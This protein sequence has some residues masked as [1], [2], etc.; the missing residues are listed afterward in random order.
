MKKTLTL[1]LFSLLFVSIGWAQHTSNPE[2]GQLQ[3]FKD[4]VELHADFTQTNLEGWTSL[5]LDGYNT[6]GS[7]HEFPGKGG[8]L[9]FIVYTPSETN[10]PNDF[11][12]YM[13]YSGKKYFASIS[14][15]DGHVNDWLIS[16]ELADHPGGTF[17]FYA[18]SSFDYGGPDAFKVGYSTTGTDPDDFIFFNGGNTTAPSLVWAKYEY[19]IPANAKHLAINCVSQAVMFLVDDLQFVHTVEPTAPAAITN[20]S[21]DS[22]IGAEIQ[23]DFEWVNPTLDKAGNALANMTGVK[24]YR[25]THP[26][27]LVEIADLSSGVGQSMSYS[28]IL[29]EGGS[30]IHRFVAYNN[31][32]NGE[33]Y[34]T[35]LTFFGYE[36]VPG[37]PRNI[38]FTQDASLHTVI[39]WDEVNYGEGGGTLENPVVGYT[40][41]RTLGNNTEILATMHPSTTFTEADIPNLNLFTY[42]IIAQTSP[43][44]YGV[45]AVVSAYSGLD[46]NQVSVTSGSNA[47]DQVFELNRSSIISQSIYTPEEL[48]GSGL[49]TSLSYFGNLGTSTTARYKIYMSTTSRETFGT[50]LDNAVWEYFGD[51]KLLFD[52]NINFP[53]GRNATT[54]ELDQPFYYDASNNENVIITIVKPLLANVPSI[55][56]REFYNTTVDGMRTYF[57]IGYSVDLS[58]ITTQPASWSTEEVPTIPSIVTK[59]ITDFGSLSGEVTRYSDNA[60]LEDVEVSVTPNGAGAYQSEIA[61]TDASGAYTIPAL[62]PGEYLVTFTKDGYNTYETSVTISSNDHQTLDAVLDQSLS[63][64]ISG[65]VV[66]AMGNGIEGATLNLTGFSND[67]AITDATGSYT[68]E[69]FSEKQYELE[70]F[71]PLYTSASVSFMSEESDYTLDPITLPL[72]A[73]KPGSVVA[74]NNNGVGNVTWRVPVGHFNET[75]IGWG[76]FLT[77]GDSWGNGGD[78][79]IAGIRFETSDLQGQLAEGAELTHV[80]AYIANNAEIIIKVFEGANGETLIHSQTASIPMEDW[81]EFELT[82]SLPIDLNKELWIGIEFL[83]GQYGAY[84]IGLDDGPNAPGRKGSMLYENGQWTAMSLTNKNWNI[85]GITNNTVDANPSGYKVYRSPASTNNWTELTPTPITATSF[86]DATLNS[87][88]PG[89]Y[90][91]GI[92]AHYENDLIS[93]KAISNE[94]Q[95]NMFFDFTLAVA[96]DFGSAEGAYVSIWNNDQ[97]AEAFV[98][99][100]ASSVTFNELIRGNYNV[101][102][103]LDNYEI[104]NLSDVLVEDNSTVTVPLTLLKV[105]PSNLDATYIG[106]TRSV[107]LDWTLHNTFTDEIEKYED[108]ERQNIGNYILKDLDGLETYTYNNFDWPNSGSPMSFMVFNPYATM[109][110]VSI[111]SYSGRRF[112]TGFAGPYGPNN[113]WLII[114]AGS[115]DF[116]FMAASLVGAEPERIRVLYST[117]GTEVS[118]FTP[119]ESVINVP[120][121]WTQYNYEAPEGTKYVAINYVSNNTYILKIDDLTYEKEYDHALSYNIYLDGELISSNVT[122]RTFLFQDLSDGSHIAEIEA[123]YET[124]V[125]EKAWI[126]LFVLDVDDH[127]KSEFRVYP[128]PSTDRFNLELESRATVTILD[129]H[130]RTLYCSVKDAGTSIIEHNF[131]SGT[132]IIRVQTEEGVSSKKLIFK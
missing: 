80:R 92:T 22:Q 46:A 63:I 109:P 115:G 117:T 111:E 45:P 77:A 100:S 42:T 106:G 12:Q 69:A 56:P 122:E 70:A 84:P 32:G 116:S 43:S 87:Q 30:Y 39:S 75:M 121:T 16:D 1:F 118:D 23:V 99:A 20:F 28:D 83:A 34:I 73:H 37:A 76:S 124:G 6:A 126:E 113:D 108:F 19:E 31:T 97:F 29:P 11:E 110:P 3:S 8:P 74:V 50:T 48:G 114:P 94:I 95:H 15:Y 36:T 2:Q 88:Q 128:N 68:L 7:Y 13:P 91:Y 104:A 18:K 54:I 72:F 89:M 119:F 86:S 4:D 35:P 132:Y 90:E 93:E 5:D 81:Y 59:K 71:H 25:G 55:N 24:I 52:G 105:K 98:P 57:A 61:L 123:V 125:S 107:T 127:K 58:L 78:P 44:D 26:M 79:F 131:A 112:L 129:I 130:G 101:R 9:G 60:A 21:M 49:I 82:S 62:L 65:T 103:E 33:A 102:V 53:A 41:R 66:D 85:Y 27:N 14:S 38:T 67:T 51:Q 120:S 96:P 10:P 40:I 17:S 64:T 47:S